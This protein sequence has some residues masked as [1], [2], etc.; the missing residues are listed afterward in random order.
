M[1]IDF[2]KILFLYLSD[3]IV[4]IIADPKLIA[5]NFVNTCH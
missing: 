4:Q 3:Y 2:L 5:G 1:G